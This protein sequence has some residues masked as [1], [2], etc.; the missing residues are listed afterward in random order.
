MISVMGLQNEMDFVKSEPGFSNES[1][2][3]SKHDG[4]GV[5]GTEEE[6]MLDISEVVN[7]DTTTI[8]PSKKNPNISCVPVLNVTHISCRLY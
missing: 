8:P 4:Y 5:I 2:V 3:P 7:Q 6:M 1:C